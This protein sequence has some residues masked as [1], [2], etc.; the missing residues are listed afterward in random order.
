MTV[1][2]M[3][4]KTELPQL[5]RFLYE[6]QSSPGGFQISRMTIKPRYTTPRYLD[7]SLQVFFYR[8]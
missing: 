7:V 4:E 5:T 2:V 8:S 1:E 6:M 3:M